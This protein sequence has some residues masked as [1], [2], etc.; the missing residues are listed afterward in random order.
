MDPTPGVGASVAESSAHPRVGREGSVALSRASSGTRRRPTPGKP[1][2]RATGPTDKPEEGMHEPGRSR[3]NSHVNLD[4]ELGGMPELMAP[5]R[6]TG[7][8]VRA[9]GQALAAGG[10]EIACTRRS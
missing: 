5:A 4:T 10:E 9:R 6:S 2:K 3:A 1:S 7:F 8:V